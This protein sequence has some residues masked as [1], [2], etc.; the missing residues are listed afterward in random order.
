MKCAFAACALLLNGCYAGTRLGVSAPVGH[1]H[2]GAVGDVVVGIGG[3]KVD[4]NRRLGG[5][6]HL[7]VAGPEGDKLVLIGAEVRGVQ[8]FTGNYRD[9]FRWLAVAH[10]AL[11]LARAQE[12]TQSAAVAGGFVGIGLGATKTDPE[13]DV[14]AGHIAFG[15]VAR[16]FFP[17]H[18]DAF[19]FLGGAFEVELDWGQ[20]R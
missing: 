5:G 3:D 17:E 20:R 11:A 19:W 8:A 6:G 18:G 14:K 7:G 13:W 16:R 15:F 2:G 9:Q 4:G 12:A 10:V 1:G